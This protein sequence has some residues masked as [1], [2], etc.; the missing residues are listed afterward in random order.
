MTI[1]IKKMLQKL[2]L[3]FIYKQN[4]KIQKLIGSKTQ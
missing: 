4:I 2:Q 1:P 3:K